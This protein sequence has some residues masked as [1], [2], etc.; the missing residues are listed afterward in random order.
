MSRIGGGDGVETGACISGEF[1]L[2]LQ[3]AKLTDCSC[4]LYTWRC[5]GYRTGCTV[6]TPIDV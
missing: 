3:P 4:D 1:R 6:L 2:W 5:I